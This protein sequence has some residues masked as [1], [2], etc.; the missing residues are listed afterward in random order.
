MDVF[1][2]TIFIDTSS[3]NFQRDLQKCDETDENIG[4]ML[5]VR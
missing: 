3:A 1:I 2:K 5:A 4:E